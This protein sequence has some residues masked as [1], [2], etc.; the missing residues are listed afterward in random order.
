MKKLFLASHFSAVARLFSDFAGDCSGKK[1]VFI[2]TAS[3]REK[4][5]FFVGLD[6]NA[7]GRL[8][9]IVD[10]LEVSSASHDEISRKIS[11]ADFVFVTGGNTFFLLQ[12]L[13]RSG[14]DKLI[15]EHIAGGKLYIGASAG[16]VVVSEDIEYLKYMDNPV[17]AP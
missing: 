10:K 6:L 5:A 3:L 17:V 9:L 4:T 15:V 16:S 7:L 14:A 2:P 13:R 12:E 11:R 1:V 8:G